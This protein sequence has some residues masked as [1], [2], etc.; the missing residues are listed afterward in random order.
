MTGRASPRL[1]PAPP[2]S[3]ATARKVMLGNRSESEVERALRSAL[4]ARGLRFRKHFPPVPGVRCRADVSFTSHQVAVFVDGCFWHRCPQHGSHPK[5]NSTWWK[6]KLD[7]NV[8]RDRRK[9]SM[10]DQ[11]GWTVVRLW[12]H[13]PLEVMVQKVLEALGASDSCSRR[14]TSV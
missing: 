8:E 14:A 6:K 12:E 3:S 10:L 7:L 2:A 5:A 11:A 13:E 1:P 9:D 4:H